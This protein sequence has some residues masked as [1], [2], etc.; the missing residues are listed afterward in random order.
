MKNIQFTEQ[1]LKYI[2]ADID[3]Q[4]QDIYRRFNTLNDRF[5]LCAS[6][7]NG[8]YH[9]DIEWLSASMACV[10][11]LKA[12]D[13]N[14]YTVENGVEFTI[15]NQPRVMLYLE[16]VSTNVVSLRKQAILNQR[17]LEQQNNLSL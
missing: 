2:N 4:N 8:K 17:K 3:D 14:A 12:F 15:N 9:I 10:I 16:D 7:P 1:E 13:V 6:L 5:Y 11:D